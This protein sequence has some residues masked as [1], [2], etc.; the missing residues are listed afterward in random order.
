MWSVLEAVRGL[1]KGGRRRG[2]AL[3]R[4]QNQT[5]LALELYGG[6]FACWQCVQ[7]QLICG[8]RRSWS[9]H[10]PSGL[11]Q[12]HAQERCAATQRAVRRDH[13]VPL[14]GLGAVPSK[15]PGI[16]AMHLPVDG[17]RLSLC[18]SLHVAK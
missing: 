15:G 3:C 9:Q 17:A 10:G 4:E 5:A 16:C 11:V 14:D 8:S 2:L 18:R 13:A 6:R 1:F 12:G 7:A